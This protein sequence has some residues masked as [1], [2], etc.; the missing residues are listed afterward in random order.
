LKQSDPQL[1][2]LAE[3]FSAARK[4]VRDLSAWAEYRKLRKEVSAAK[5]SRNV[6]RASL[7][8]EDHV[9]RSLQAELKMVQT[10]VQRIKKEIHESRDDR[11]L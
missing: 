8:R 5:K 6:T 4:T 7:L 1:R 10:R 2:R 9:L 3:E 11:V